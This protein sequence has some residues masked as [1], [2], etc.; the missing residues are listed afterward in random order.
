[1]PVNDGCPAHGDP[2][3]I[4]WGVAA[5]DGNLRRRWDL[6]ITNDGGVAA[7]AGGEDRHDDDHS[8]CDDDGND[9]CGADAAPGACAFVAVRTAVVFEVDVDVEVVST[10]VVPS[11]FVAAFC[12]NLCTDVDRGVGGL[13]DGCRNN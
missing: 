6:A 8:H 7:A 10:T 2:P 5:M 3:G 11:A 1:D 9:G 12:A 13:R 4:P